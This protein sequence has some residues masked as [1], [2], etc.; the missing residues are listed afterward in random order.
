MTSA[1]LQEGMVACTT[2]PSPLGMLCLARSR[3]GLAQVRLANTEAPCGGDDPLLAEARHQLEQ[4][5]AGNRRRFDLPLDLRATSSTP[6][7]RRVWQATR[8]I[9]YGAVRSYGEIARAIDS[10][11]AA[12]AVGQALGRNPLLIVVPCHRVVRSDG[13]LG[14]FGAG[15]DNKRALLTLEGYLKD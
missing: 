14:G 12:R 5:F 2:M 6:F 8:Q 9:P 11:R 1:S 10:P 13:G 15:L 7:Q 4:Y 3:E